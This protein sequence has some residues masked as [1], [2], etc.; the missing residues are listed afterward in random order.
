MRD[1]SC[2]DGT[3]KPISIVKNPVTMTTYYAVI[4]VNNN[5]PFE[6]PQQLEFFVYNDY[7]DDASK[8]KYSYVKGIQIGSYSDLTEEILKV[9]K[10]T[11]ANKISYLKVLFKVKPDRDPKNDTSI[12]IEIE[13]STPNTVK[14]YKS[15]ISLIKMS[16]SENLYYA[17][18]STEVGSSLKK[19]GIYSAD[20]KTEYSI[21]TDINVK[22]EYEF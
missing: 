4:R 7:K 20:Q 13:T 8:K 5:L 17:Y 14:E 9:S 12:Y 3:F 11:I 2:C 18:V 15:P 6:Y 10:V 1:D 22:N 21:A 16:N 19:I